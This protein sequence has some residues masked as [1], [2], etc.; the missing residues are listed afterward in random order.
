MTITLT[1]EQLLTSASDFIEHDGFEPLIFADHTALLADSEPDSSG[2][3]SIRTWTLDSNGRPDSPIQFVTSWD[4]RD[5]IISDF[6]SPV[7]IVYA[8]EELV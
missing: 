1:H 2:Y 5:G 3:V 4:G 7:D 6:F 8:I